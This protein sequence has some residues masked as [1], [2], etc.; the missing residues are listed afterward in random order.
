MTKVNVLLYPNFTALD[1]FGPVEALGNIDI[2]ELHYISLNGGIVSNNQNIR[3]ETE[4]ISASDKNGILLVPGG[5]GSRTLVED[6]K[7]L[8]ALA[9]AVETAEY[10]LCV[11]TGSAL[12]AKTGAL[13]GLNATT[14][15]TAFD[16]V[17]SCGRNVKWNREAR[18]VV[19]GKFYTSA[20]VSAGT[21]MALGFISDI[22]GEPQAE[23]ICRR[24]E[25]HRNKCAEKD[26]F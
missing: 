17:K 6:K 12:V 2:Y 22:F 20:G 4:S 25:Y 26:I 1:V 8:A 19:D 15:K 5:Y 3:I 16:W 21:D 23:T 10:V 24:M 11:C 13:D 9:K 18:W 7:F 14:N